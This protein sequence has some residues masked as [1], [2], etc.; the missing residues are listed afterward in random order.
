MPDY[1]AWTINCYSV[2]NAANFYYEYKTERTL[3]DFVFGIGLRGGAS[4]T[5]AV[6]Q[7]LGFLVLCPFCHQSARLQAMVH[8]MPWA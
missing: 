1:S 8:G 3:N 7:L 4:T 2:T 5:F 6:V